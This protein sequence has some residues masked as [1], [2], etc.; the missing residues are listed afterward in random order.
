MILILTLNP[1]LE[2]RFYYSQISDTLVNRDGRVIYQAG[3]KGINVSRQLKKL[4]INS[5][6]IFFSGGQNGKKLREL[7]RN[8]QLP[9]TSIHTDEETRHAA[10]II[11]EKDKKI[12]S[13]FSSNPSVSKKEADL[14]KENITKMLTNSEIII[15]SGS[16][17]SP[18]AEEIVE[19]AISEA[20][21]LD[22]ISVCDYYGKN[23]Q[24]V[25]NLSPTIVHNN[26]DEID[27]YL[28]VDLKDEKNVSAFLNENF[29]KA[30]KRVY[31][32]DGGNPFFAQNFDYLYKITPPK[33][34]AV[35]STGS[36]DAFV[37]GII[38][39]WKDNT[40][41]EYS[42]K[43][44]TALASANA[45]S[46]NVCNVEKDSFEYLI[47][48]VIINHIGKKVKLIDDNPTFH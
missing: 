2:R 21:R 1:L 44:S 23:L 18:Y 33:I 13:F 46:F 9:F 29:G 42:L 28:K 19:F 6:N 7:L 39:C 45:T 36:G 26:F 4:G 34:D 24:Q 43:Y 10:I 41:F 38:K 12:L 27:K 32:T 31:L 30:I 5:Q 17:P 14:M 47:D 25:L 16:A 8:E 3:G 15:V 40:V 11:S 22:K 35:D 48:Q 20:N 37:A